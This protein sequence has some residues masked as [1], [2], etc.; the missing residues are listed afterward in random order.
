MPRASS[1]MPRRGALPPAASNRGGH[2]SGA[3]TQTTARPLPVAA[4]AGVSKKPSATKSTRH[5]RSAAAPRVAVAAATLF[6]AERSSAPS[7]LA[8]SSSVAEQP[9]AGMKS[10][11]RP[12]LSPP[13]APTRVSKRLAAA[14]EMFKTE[15][16]SASPLAP[17][18][19]PSSVAEQPGAVIKLEHRPP[20]IPPA[21]PARVSKRRVAAAT[22]PV[23]TSECIPPP[24]NTKL[25]VAVTK[26]EREP[27]LIPTTVPAR[28]SKRLAAATQVPAY[29]AEC[30]PPAPSTKP[31]VAVHTT[32]RQPS[33]A[34]S[35][36][37]TKRPDVV[38]SPQR[39]PRVA[40]TG[41]AGKSR[42]RAHRAPPRVPRP[43]RAGGGA[44]VSPGP[45]SGFASARQRSARLAVAVAH[46]QQAAPQVARLLTAPGAFAPP[47]RK[48]PLFDA[49]ARS[50]LYQQVNGSTARFLY[51]RLGALLYPDAAAT[52]V[53]ALDFPPLTP[54]GVLGLGVD[55][56]RAMG[57][58]ASKARFIVGAAAACA[59][60]S[61]GL[62]ERRL[63][64]L[65]DAQVEAVLRALPGVGAW[66]VAM[67]S[68]FV[69]ERPD[70]LPA[71]DL[72]LRRG[73]AALW[74]VAATATAT[75]ASTREGAVK[76]SA[77]ATGGAKV[78]ARIKAKASRVAAAAGTEGVPVAPAPALPAMVTAEGMERLFESCRPFRS[79]AVWALWGV[80]D[81]RA[82]LPIGGVLQ[83]MGH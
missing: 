29:S 52:D 80:T 43:V 25:P 12:P 81:E 58:S 38:P 28:V 13:A 7:P 51:A 26:S 72:T 83:R 35:A 45:L 23:S 78:S 4:P 18:A 74:G 24:P 71:G 53:D 19:S 61:G 76:V 41:R 56:V 8:P 77:N 36:A 39:Q 34:V 17:P 33:V 50:I 11:R 60:K 32:G 20:L 27:P 59:A 22:T 37:T 68:M 63:G 9:G 66:T 73:A 42:A 64:L 30:I 15:P 10:E 75:A 48:A 21:V 31:L 55:G 1:A 65:D 54:K 69:L 16:L 82:F 3:A 40:P 2:R 67:V 5:P 6:K 47:F 49:L 70:V 57:V 14:A 46:L 62:D 44:A 79:Y